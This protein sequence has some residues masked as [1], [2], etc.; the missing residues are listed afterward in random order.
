MVWPGPWG[1]G[2]WEVSMGVVRQWAWFSD[3]RCLVV[4]ALNDGRGSVVGVAQW[5]LCSARGVARR[6]TVHS[7]R[8]GST[9]GVVRW[10]VVLSGGRGSAMGGAR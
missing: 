7:S 1:A 5:W 10:W 2:W 6:W 9:M 4:A 8:R 3:R